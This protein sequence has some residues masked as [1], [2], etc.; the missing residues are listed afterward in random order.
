[1]ARRA[2][3]WG[4]DDRSTTQGVAYGAAEQQAIAQAVAEAQRRASG[5]SGASG[6]SA[7]TAGGTGG[8]VGYGNIVRHEY[9]LRIP[10]KIGSVAVGLTDKVSLDALTQYLEEAMAAKK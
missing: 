7:S 2:S 3:L 6:T 8:A 10:A 9:V 4:R 1:M 5:S